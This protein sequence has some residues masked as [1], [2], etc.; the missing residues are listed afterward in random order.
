MNPFS[1][2]T[3]EC[4]NLINGNANRFNLHIHSPAWFIDIQLVSD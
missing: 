4:D 2:D 3:I 1:S